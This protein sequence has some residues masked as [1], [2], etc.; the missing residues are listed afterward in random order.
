MR[1]LPRR[2][3]RRSGMRTV[4]RSLRDL[5]KESSQLDALG[6]VAT[7][8]NP[9]RLACSDSSAASPQASRG[10]SPP[11][12]RPLL[13]LPARCRSRRW[14]A[15]AR[16]SQIMLVG[17][18]NHTLAP[19]SLARPRPLVPAERLGDHPTGECPP[20][21]R[22]RLRSKAWTSRCGSFDATATAY[23]DH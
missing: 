11:R 21:L 8:S 17:V 16:P 22:I 2:T 15:G 5:P 9:R 6:R 23:P 14:G 13:R 7:Y 12:S 18:S 10:A 4:R 3:S 20:N 19:A 1:R